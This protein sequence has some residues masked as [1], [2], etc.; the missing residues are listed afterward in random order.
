MIRIAAFGDVHIGEDSTGALAPL[1]TDLGE[2]ADLLAVA[3]DLTRC[4]S[5]REAEV[6]AA[7]L[8]GID[9]PIVAVLGNHDY[10]SDCPHEV[11]D[12]LISIG[13]QVLDG[14]ATVI[15]VHDSQVAIAGVKGFGGGFPGASG[16]SFGEAEMKA[17]MRASHSAA[18]RLK[19]ALETTAHADVRVALTHYAPTPDTLQG[20]RLE[21]YPFLG[22]GLLAEA[23]D[24]GRAHLALHGHAHR[25]SEQGTTPGGVPV[26]NVAQPVIAAPYRVYCV[27]LDSSAAEPDEIVT[28]RVRVGPTGRG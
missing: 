21:I 25:G 27:E 15:D 7:E 5:P 22:S 28:D 12:A 13:A 2:R 1:L 17:F 19:S 20:E 6:L 11:A 23:I 18:D 9:V 8:V 10:H 4:G 14:E 24:E 3:G 16:S 26:R